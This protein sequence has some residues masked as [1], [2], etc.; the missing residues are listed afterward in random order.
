MDVQLDLPGSGPIRLMAASIGGKDTVI[1]WKSRAETEENPTTYAVANNPANAV[2]YPVVKRLDNATVKVST[3]FNS[4]SVL[5]KVPLAA[6]G[7]NASLGSEIKGMV[8]VIF[9]DPSGT[10]RASRV[11]WHNKST[12]LVSDVPSEAR[13]DPSRW[14]TIAVDK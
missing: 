12:G 13:L 4:Y 10:N 11:Y 2:T 6:L 14:G 5:I 9:S 8:G 1:L 7:L 3:G